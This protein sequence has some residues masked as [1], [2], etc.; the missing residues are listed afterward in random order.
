MKEWGVTPGGYIILF[1]VL[2]WSKI[3]FW[4]RLY[5]SEYTY[6]QEVVCFKWGWIIVSI[7]V[8]ISLCFHSV[9]KSCLTLCNPVD[10]S[11]PGFPVLHYLL[12]FG[13]CS[14]SGQL[15]WWYPPTISSSAVLFSCPQSFWV[16]GSFPWVSSLHQVAKYWS[17]SFSISPS[18][19]YSV[20]GFL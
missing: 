14:N 20:L 9:A 1:E 10:C 16:S 11:V 13:V 3:I 4:W 6:H 18:D 5:N 17:F 2:K 15:S 19:A 8:F 7:K 12:E